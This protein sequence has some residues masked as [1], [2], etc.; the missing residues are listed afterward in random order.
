M[1]PVCWPHALS[2]V[3]EG[4]RSLG[5]ASQRCS[6]VHFG[7][8]REGLFLLPIFLKCLLDSLFKVIFQGRHMAASPLQSLLLAEP[9]EQIRPSTRKIRDQSHVQWMCVCVC[10]RMHFCARPVEQPA[11]RNFAETV[12]FVVADHADDAQHPYLCLRWIHVGAHHV[13]RC[14]AVVGHSGECCWWSFDDNVMLLNPGCTPTRWILT[15]DDTCSRCCCYY[16]SSIDQEPMKVQ[17]VAAG[18]VGG[19]T[20]SLK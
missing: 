17:V 11:V 10:A 16:W 14:K 8:S 18:N 9:Q 12:K 20:S 1:V 7:A 3:V 5:L 13:Q 15:S 19:R 6:A 4:L 2:C